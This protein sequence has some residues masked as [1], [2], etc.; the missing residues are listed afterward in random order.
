MSSCWKA[1]VVSSLPAD[2]AHQLL[3]GL[4]LRATTI[5]VRRA[6]LIRD[7]RG[8]SVD[9]QIA[10]LRPELDFAGLASLTPVIKLAGAFHQAVL[11]DRT[12]PH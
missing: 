3:A 8:D 11:D 6:E 12:A 10:T 9:D 1:S 4:N 7:A 5:N 2:L